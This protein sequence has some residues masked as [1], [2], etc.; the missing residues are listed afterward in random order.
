MCDTSPEEMHWHLCSHD[1]HQNMSVSSPSLP[2]NAYDSHTPSSDLIRFAASE[3]VVLRLR[4][5]DRSDFSR[6]IDCMRRALSSPSI[7]LEFSSAPE[8][9]RP[10]M[11]QFPASA[12]TRCGLDAQPRAGQT[13]LP[14][15][16]FSFTVLNLH[17]T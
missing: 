14:T 9:S 11:M 6:L 12:Y 15:M 3:G 1:F 13:R 8:T 5:V 4:N 2:G 7:R 17:E 16:P 10:G